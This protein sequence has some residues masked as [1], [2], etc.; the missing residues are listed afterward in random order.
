MSTG[1]KVNLNTVEQVITDRQSTGKL[2]E[3]FALQYLQRS[4][5]WRI[6]LKNW[7]CRFGE[8][9]I[10]AYDRA[11][12]VVIE[13]RTRRGTACGTAAESVDRRKRRQ[14]KRLL[15]A[16]LQTLGLDDEHPVRL[17]VIALAVHHTE[18]FAMEHVKDALW[19][20]I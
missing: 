8:L 19:E 17:D 15:P 9:D 12:L 13:V 18:I 16:L 7:R 5:G 10:V 14:L 4:L 20:E 6:C 2:G 1:P 3:A 11:M